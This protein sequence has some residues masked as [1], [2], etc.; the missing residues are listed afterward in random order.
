M[1]KNEREVV[2]PTNFDVHTTNS[3]D[4]VKDF[5]DYKFSTENLAPRSLFDYYISIRMFLRWFKCREIYRSNNLTM[6]DFR[7]TGIEDVTFEEITSL[8][9][10]DVA[11]FNSFCASFLHNSSSTRASRMSAVSSM[12]SYFCIIKT[13]ES[14]PTVALK[15]P[16]RENRTPRYLT[17]QETSDLLNAVKDGDTYTRD[18]CMI[19][20]FVNLGLRLSELASINLHDI[21]NGNILIHGKE[22]KDR[23]LPLNDVCTE[24]LET[25]L[26]DRAAYPE[27]E[28][29]ALF[30][31][32]LKNY[33]RL[34]TRRIEQIV[35]D[36]L[37]RAG[38]AGRGFS[39]HSLR[40]TRATTLSEYGV[41]LAQI[42]DIMGHANIS[43]TDIYTHTSTASIIESLNAVQ[44]QKQP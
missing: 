34:S 41:P 18:Y 13:A 4:F 8:D 35:S 27:H 44:L 40:H 30:I 32:N 16:R 19:I 9:T 26:H 31:S 29:N 37:A 1:Q 6:E 38:L 17:E 12:Y 36:C 21:S 15:R 39:P 5:I 25:Y 28:T 3:P 11:E 10:R 42:R 43:S 33:K 2:S 14:D 22:R 23:C 24:A 7:N 20:F